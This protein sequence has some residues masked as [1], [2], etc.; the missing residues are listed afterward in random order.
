M[1]KKT[2]VFLA[3]CTLCVGVVAITGI[4]KQNNIKEG[5]EVEQIEEITCDYNYS[6]TDRS[7]AN[8]TTERVFVEFKGQVDND[9]IKTI[10]DDVLDEVSQ[11][12]DKETIKVFI[13]DANIEKKDYF[14]I[15]FKP[16]VYRYIAQ[17]KKI[18]EVDNIKK[19]FGMQPTKEDYELFE[20]ALDEMDKLINKS[21][22][23][24]IITYLDTVDKIDWSKYNTTKE[25]AKEVLNKVSLWVG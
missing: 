10:A 20:K 2:K 13:Y 16:V 18:T 22:E 6:I 15:P 17:N 25:N 23:D 9:S 4:V 3:V 11:D 19:D 24:N 7:E 21:E 12:S 8:D 1:N 14:G 5:K